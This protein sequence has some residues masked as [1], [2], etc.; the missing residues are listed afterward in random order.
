MTDDHNENS[1]ETRPKVG[2]L[3]IVLTTLAAAIGVQNRKN[4]EKDFAQSS[5]LPYI[6]AGIIFTILFLFTLIF[7]AK[8]ALAA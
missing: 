3:A 5:P 1:P 7:I 2:F 6:V 4:L 8:L